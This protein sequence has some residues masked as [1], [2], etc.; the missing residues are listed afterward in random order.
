MNDMKIINK[1][2]YKLTINKDDLFVIVEINKK[3]ITQQHFFTRREWERLI[4][5]ITFK[6]MFKIWR[7]LK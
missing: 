5:F 3:E 4:K 7:A 2:G 6:N 1:D